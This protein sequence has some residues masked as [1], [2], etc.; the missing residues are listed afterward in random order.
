[1][2]AIRR[3]LAFDLGA[4]NG[5]A[6]V[7]EFDGSALRCEDIYHFPNEPVR[8]LGDFHWDLLRLFGDIKRG[9]MEYARRYGPEVDGIGIDTWGVDFA[10]I[11]R[12]G[13]MLGNPHHYRDN[14]SEGRPEQIASEVD[15]YII[16]RTTGVQLEQVSTICQ[17]YALA[18][19]RS[20]QLEIADCFL[21]VPSLLSYFLT[22]TRVQEH[23]NISNSGLW[24]FE[25]DSPSSDIL[26]G[27]GIPRRIMPDVIRPGTAVGNLTGP[28][29]EECGLGNAPVFVPATHDTASAVISVPA[30]PSTNWAFLSCGTWSVIGIETDRP[31]TSRDAFEAGVTSAATANGK[32]MPRLN[33]T[34][35]WILQ[36]LRRIWEKQGD[37]L[38]WGTMVEMAENAPKFAAFMDVD[39]PEFA[40]PP[41]MPAAIAGY[42]RKTGQSVPDDKG[43]MIRVVMESLALK[44]REKLAKIESLSGRKKEVLHIVGGGVRNTLLCRFTAGSTGIPVVAGPVEATS[45]GNLLVQMMGAGVFSSVAEGRQALRESFEVVDYAPTDTTEWDE[46]YGKYLSVVSRPAM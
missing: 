44:Y 20:P 7:G 30:D 18:K 6:V 16:Y 35:L 45:T 39:S 9:L 19:E 27:L 32:Y 24:G 11:D 34:G 42:L 36:E 3:F 4:S 15:P 31:I 29:R 23:S 12:D 22:G 25:S 1:M 17:L 10:L 38:D 46:A 2:R 40:S 26:D 41:D 33:I 43:G 21:M 37:K 5:R 13:R 8:V 28:I 14:R